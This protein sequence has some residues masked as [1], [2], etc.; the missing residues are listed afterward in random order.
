LQKSFLKI[1]KGRK[2]CNSIFGPFLRWFNPVTPYWIF[3][4]NFIDPS[5]NPF[6]LNL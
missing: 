2:F 5:L 3:R 6:D 4:N 1:S